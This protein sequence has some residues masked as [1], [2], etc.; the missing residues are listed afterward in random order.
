MA[1]KIKANKDSEYRVYFFRM[2]KDVD[3]ELIE[4]L[5]NNVFNF[6]EYFRTLVRADKENFES[7]QKYEQLESKIKSLE[8]SNKEIMNMIIELRESNKSK[9]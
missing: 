6:T 9:Q 1:K 5:D 2:R 7:K 4:Y 8:K 3:A